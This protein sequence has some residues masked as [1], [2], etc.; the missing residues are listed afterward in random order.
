MIYHKTF[1]L[2]T[3]K[4]HFIPNYVWRNV[5]FSTYLHVPGIAYSIDRTLG[6]CSVNPIQLGDFG[7]QKDKQAYMKNGAYVIKM[8]GPLDIFSM[9]ESYRW[10]GQVSTQVVCDE[11]ENKKLIKD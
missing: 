6:N 7:A 8:K 5:Y 4:H 11:I 1:H 10:A 2:M 9:N 3:L